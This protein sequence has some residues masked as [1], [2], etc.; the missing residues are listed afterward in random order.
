MAETVEENG[1]KQSKLPYRF[2]L[3][4]AQAM[5]ALARVMYEGVQKYE[6]NNWR[7]ISVES[8]LNHALSHVYA[9]LAHD[10]QDDHL[11]H[12]LTRLHMAVAIK[13]EEDD[14]NGKK[15][16]LSDAKP[17]NDARPSSDAR[18]RDTSTKPVS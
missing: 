12:A 5:F 13:L 11:T 10:T 3:V 1:G 6:P 18:P 9:Y 15:T 14:K 4:D 7:K 2:D 8:H 16:K 17:T